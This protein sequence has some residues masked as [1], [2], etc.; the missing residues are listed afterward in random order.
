MLAATDIE[1]QLAASMAYL[2]AGVNA[3]ATPA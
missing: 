1:A 2:N 3:L